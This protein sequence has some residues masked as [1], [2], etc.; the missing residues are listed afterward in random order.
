MN[1]QPARAL[2]DLNAMQQ[3]LDLAAGGVRQALTALL[4]TLTPELPL[5]QAPAEVRRAAAPALEHYWLLDTIDGAVQYLSGLPLW[6]LSLC[7]VSQGRPAWALIHEPARGVL[8]QARAGQGAWCDGRRLQ[9]QDRQPLALAVLGTS[10][11]NYPPRPQAE[12]DVFM[13]T[14]AR[15]VPRVFAQRWMG[16]ASLSLAQLAA[17]QLD[18]YWELGGSCYDWMA[19]TLLAEEAGARLS[20]LSGPPLTWASTGIL[21]ASPAIYT[22]LA[23]ALA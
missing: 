10:F 9:C 19:G 1:Q 16:P 23:A 11:P 21:A 2:P 6:T 13:T 12:L 22:E 5:L 18:G 17:G 20:D 14:L 15:A 8:W 7:L 4:A 3:R